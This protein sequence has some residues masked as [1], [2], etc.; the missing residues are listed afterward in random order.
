MAPATNEPTRR[1][2]TYSAT[3]E[4][5]SSTSFENRV[6]PTSSENTDAHMQA[7]PEICGSRC[8]LE[9]EVMNSFRSCD[10]SS[11]P[12]RRTPSQGFRLVAWLWALARSPCTLESGFYS[13][14]AI[15][16]KCCDDDEFQTIRGV[17]ES[18]A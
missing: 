15:G 1:F 10:R 14:N 3:T 13:S 16:R 6:N 11:S 4:A 7:R 5:H 17:M 9:R 12:S 2:R 18:N 8:D